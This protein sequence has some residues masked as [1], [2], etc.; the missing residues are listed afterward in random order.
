MIV[1]VGRHSRCRGGTGDGVDVCVLKV[2]MKMRHR[3]TWQSLAETKVAQILVERAFTETE[4]C[5]IGIG[6]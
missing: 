6:G 1:T 2:T 5:Q 3:L 4:C